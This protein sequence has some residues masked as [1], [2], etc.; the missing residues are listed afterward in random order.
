MTCNYLDVLTARKKLS[1]KKTNSHF[2]FLSTLWKGEVIICC[3]N[4]V[5]REM[6]NIFCTQNMEPEDIEQLENIIN[7]FIFGGV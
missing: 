1:L 3:Y 2:S 6:Y 4:H 7:D 5:Y